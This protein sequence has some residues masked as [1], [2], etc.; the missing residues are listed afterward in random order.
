MSA[1]PMNIK[2]TNTESQDL[3]LFSK[4]HYGG[5]ND[6]TMIPAIRYIVAQHLGLSVNTSVLTIPAL[7]GKVGKAVVEFNREAFLANDCRRVLELMS[8]FARDVEGTFGKL[9]YLLTSMVV[10]APDGKRLYDLPPVNAALNDG[11]QKYLAWFDW[12][13]RL[14]IADDVYWTD[15][16]GRESGI[17]RLSDKFP[18]WGDST[19]CEIETPTGPIIRA[20]LADLS[21]VPTSE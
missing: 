8:G 13:Q 15:P 16:K 7:I 9:L 19:Y 21:P 14:E 2:T 6:S 1:F 20:E 4:R 18:T 17:Y 12:F 3:L 11:L 10:V 5:Y